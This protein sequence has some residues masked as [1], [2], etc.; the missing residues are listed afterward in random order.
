MPFWIHS[1]HLFHGNPTHWVNNTDEWDTFWKSQ[2]NGFPNFLFSGRQVVG[3]LTKEHFMLNKH[4]ED[5]GLVVNVS[6]LIS[7]RDVHLCKTFL[8]FYPLE[9]YDSN[10]EETHKFFIKT[11]LPNFK[12]P[13]VENTTSYPMMLKC[14]EL[15]GADEGVFFVLNKR[16]C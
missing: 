7:F 12:V 1:R 3:T 11:Y 14:A 16:F 10:I 5:F 2:I 6:N 13:L 9:K 8:S 4:W 15:D